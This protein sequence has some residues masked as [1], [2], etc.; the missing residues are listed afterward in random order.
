MR[1][2]I[3]NADDFG[4]TAGVNRAIVEAHS[5]GVVTSTTLMANVPAFDDAVQRAILSPKISVGCHVM[6]VDGSPILGGSRAASLID[7]HSTNG[8][9]F[10]ESL[11]GFAANVLLSRI[12]AE[13]IEAEATA[14]IR[15]LQ[16]AGITVSHFDTHK[17]THM[18]PAVL[19]PLLRAAKVCGIHA[20]RN[21]FTPWLP[22]LV[23]PRA[24]KRC[25]EVRA[26]HKLA[27]AFR[28]IAAGHDMLTPDGTFGIAAA[29]DL[30]L[31]LFQRIVERLPEGTWEFVCHPGYH[32]GEL[33]KTRTR[34][35]ESRVKELKILTSAAARQALARCGVELISYRDFAA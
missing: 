1:R 23:P 2:L 24:W 16:S 15:K 12:D 3:I 4:L 35:R 13:A 30:S 6:L 14:Q 22:I 25:L 8:T 20:V 27:G 31:E 18:L 33:D 32:D 28:R 21:P 11:G 17:H 26:L 5:H 19:R 10:R 7:P 34:L 29:G 9:R